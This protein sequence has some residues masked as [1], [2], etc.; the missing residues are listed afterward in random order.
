MIRVMIVSGHA[1]LRAR[2]AGVLNQWPGFEVSA[3]S[4]D[5]YDALYAA[6]AFLP[7]VALLDEDPSLLGC[8]GLVAALKRWSPAT[9]SVVLAAS[10][11]GRAVLDSVAAGAAGYVLKGRDADIVP[12]VLWAHRGGVLMTAEAA[13]RAFGKTPG[14]KPPRPRGRNPGLT[15]ADLEILVRVGRGLSGK[16]IAAELRLKHGTVR[17][18]VSALLRKTGLKSRTEIALFAHRA[19]ILGG[20]GAPPQA[21]P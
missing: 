21:G 8:P 11:A 12:A 1:G 2:I 19:G 18:R 6:R 9:R 7:H 3:G 10:P 16:E 4:R 15:R 13:A 5:S 17:N 14:G 20:E